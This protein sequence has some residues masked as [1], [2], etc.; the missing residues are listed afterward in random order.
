MYYDTGKIKDNFLFSAY[1]CTI[2]LYTST[3]TQID[4]KHAADY[5]GGY[6]TRSVTAGHIQTP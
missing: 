4:I 6:N 1:A 5:T 3:H 2:H